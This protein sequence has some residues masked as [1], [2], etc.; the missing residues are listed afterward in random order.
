MTD[1]PTEQP[2]QELGYAPV[3]ARISGLRQATWITLLVLGILTA[4]GGLCLG[5]SM[6]FA[7]LM[8]TK[9]VASMPRSAPAAP[10]PSPQLFWLIGGITAAIPLA[11]GTTEIVCSVKIRRGSHPASV[12]ALAVIGLQFLLVGAALLFGGV[13][14]AMGTMHGGPD[15]PAQVLGLAFYGII[16]I[17]LGF[18]GFLLIKVL[19]EA[20][21]GV[22]R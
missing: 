11:F 22:L 8:F 7:A 17:A 5:G 19:G 14:L 1:Y 12:V 21:T 6:A 4:L 13:G 18:L 20:R 2:I 10:L 3:S 16:E 15:L 9:L